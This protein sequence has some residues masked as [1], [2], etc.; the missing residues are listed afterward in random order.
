MNHRFEEGLILISYRLWTWRGS[1]TK[2]Q[3]K[4]LKESS[5]WLNF[6]ELARE[7]WNKSDVLELPRLSSDVCEH[8][9]QNS[10]IFL[11]RLN[12]TNAIIRDIAMIRK[13]LCTQGLHGRYILHKKRLQKSKDKLILQ[14]QQSVHSGQN[15][16]STQRIWNYYCK[17]LLH[18]YMNQLCTF[19]VCK[20]LLLVGWFRIMKA[21]WE[22]I[23]CHSKTSKNEMNRVLCW[24]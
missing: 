6:S 22:G 10:L 8:F 4:I 24:R 23:F 13:Y 2:I 9:N 1:R 18:K 20:Q 5:F 12:F 15:D 21:E 14:I 11:I 7:Q 16:N 19:Y 17:S 3:W